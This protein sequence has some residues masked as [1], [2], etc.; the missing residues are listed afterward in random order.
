VDSVLSRKANFQ[1]LFQKCE[2]S[3]NIG[4]KVCSIAQKK[5]KII[6]HNYI[7]H[8]PFKIFQ[9]WHLI[10]VYTCNEK[11]ASV[12][13]HETS[14]HHISG[15]SGPKSAQICLFASLLKMRMLK[16]PQHFI[17]SKSWRYHVTRCVFNSFWKAQVKIG[18]F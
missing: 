3:K 6:V 13:F 4:F 15:G 7:M 8:C 14:T 9:N 5:E 1:N 12:L 17:G 16:A 11:T 18:G 10:R 2:F